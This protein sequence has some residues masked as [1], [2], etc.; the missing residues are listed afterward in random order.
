MISRGL[1]ELTSIVVFQPSTL[2]NRPSEQKFTVSYKTLGKP[3]YLPTYPYIPIVLRRSVSDPTTLSVDAPYQ[4][5]GLGARK[6]EA[7][8]LESA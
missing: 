4:R 6:A 3:T 2:N 1:F 7:S 5:L 8:V